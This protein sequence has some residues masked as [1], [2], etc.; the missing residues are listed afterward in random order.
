MNTCTCVYNNTHNHSDLHVHLSCDCFAYAVHCV[1]QLCTVCRVVM[2]LVRAQLLPSGF[3]SSS[4][5]HDVHH[6]VNSNN[7]S[8]MTVMYA[9]MPCMPTLSSWSHCYMYTLLQNILNNVYFNLR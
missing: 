6:C 8:N 7:R 9:C 1:V 4:R 2:L 5:I 3:K